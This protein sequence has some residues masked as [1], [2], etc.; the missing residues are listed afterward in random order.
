MAF[1]QAILSEIVT[2]LGLDAIV[3]SMVTISTPAVV[4]RDSL[5]TL[6]RDPGDHILDISFATLDKQPLSFLPESH[7]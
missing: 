2:V 1:S 4:R 7:N 5:P 6:R 3:S